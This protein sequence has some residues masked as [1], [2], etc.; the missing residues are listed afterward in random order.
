MPRRRCRRHML[1]AADSA[2]FRHCRRR[3]DDTLMLIRH[4]LQLLPLRCRERWRDAR[5]RCR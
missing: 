2:D 3:A 1:D 4:S 5:L